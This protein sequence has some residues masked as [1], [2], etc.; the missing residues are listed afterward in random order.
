MDALLALISVNFGLISFEKL[1]QK[2]NERVEY[3]IS[4]MKGICIN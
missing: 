1:L 4:D 3:K 2:V